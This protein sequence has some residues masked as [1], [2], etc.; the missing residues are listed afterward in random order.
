MSALHCLTR[1][2]CLHAGLYLCLLSCLS[3]TLL[4]AAEKPRTI[5]DPEWTFSDDFEADR[6]AAFWGDG[7]SVVYGAEAETASS[8]VLAFNYIKNQPDAR[9]AWSEQ[10]FYIPIQAQQLEISYKLYV[11]ANYKN[12][13]KNHKGI[14]LW[15]G[16]YGKSHAN[17][18]VSSESWGVKGG[19]SPS[20]YIGV[21]K[22]NY[23]H[24]RLKDNALMLKDGR[25]EWID[26]HVYLELAEQD[27]DVGLFELYR[28]GELITGTQHPNLSGNEAQSW[29]PKTSEQ[30]HYSKMGNYIN[31]GY[32]LGWM[33]GGVTEDTQFLIDDFCIKASSK[34]GK[35]VRQVISDSID[36]Q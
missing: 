14:I 7:T 8:K 29:R 27:G 17:I 15:S 33:N 26:V 31:K 9:N 18:S 3:V 34:V 30:I 36:E 5:V 22:H 2:L 23:G 24:T 13:G 28:N 12:S 20:V 25:A 32:V 1:S 19:A 4:H 10:R 21:D 16:K 11:P 35:S 6:N